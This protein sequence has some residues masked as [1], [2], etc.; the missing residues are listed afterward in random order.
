MPVKSLCLIAI[1]IKKTVLMIF[2]AALVFIILLT[3][4]FKTKCRKNGL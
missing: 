3:I 2:I 1:I 4:I